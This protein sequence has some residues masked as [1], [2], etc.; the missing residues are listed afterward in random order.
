MAGGWPRRD[1]SFHG[2]HPGQHQMTKKR[3]RAY[4]Y[5]DL[6]TAVGLL[7]PVIR[8]VAHDWV[9]RDLLG[10]ALGYA[11]GS[12]GN[13][14][15]KIAALVQYG[16]LERRS[17]QYRLSPLARRM[18]R[19]DP[20]DSLSADYLRRAFYNPALFRAILS[21]IQVEG[22]LP[23]HLDEMLIRKHGIT[24]SASG[25]VAE[26]F[27]R[28]GEFAGV[29]LPD[30]TLFEPVDREE[31]SAVA[32]KPGIP[33]K[34]EFDFS[35]LLSDRQKAFSTYKL[36][37]GMSLQD[38]E[39]FEKDALNRID[40]LRT[41]LGFAGTKSPGEGDDKKAALQFMRPK[42]GNRKP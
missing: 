34:W 29:L 38:F 12:G 25:R 17:G 41:H 5:L 7:G 2:G 4:P 18:G 1:G 36:P 37:A 8:N 21:G 39:T 32:S 23:T 27:R 3:S 10:Q 14:A 16:L 33:G 30:G 13:A 40:Q 20:K 24:D 31:P 28:S 22:H 9:D 15:R 35:V 19:S 6:E 26:V 11:S 42:K